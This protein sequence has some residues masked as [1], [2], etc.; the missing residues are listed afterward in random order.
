[1]EKSFILT[2][3]VGGSVLAAIC[4]D[5]FHLVNRTLACR[6]PEQRGPGARP[7]DPVGNEAMLLLEF[8]HR[9]LGD[10]IERAGGGDP[11]FVLDFLNQVSRGATAQRW[12]AC[13]W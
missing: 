7:D 13:G 8:A 5:Q 1:R 4:S 6:L 3:F 11:H 10:R 9:R 12:A 2:R